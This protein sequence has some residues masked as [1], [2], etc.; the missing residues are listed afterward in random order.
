MELQKIREIVAQIDPAVSVLEAEAFRAEEDGMEYQVWKLTT[1]ETPLVLKKVNPRERETYVGF[2]AHGGPVPKVFC[3]Y[4]DWML[5]EYIPGHTLSRCRRDDLILTLDALIESQRTFWN[6]EDL[7]HVGYGFEK[8]YPNR[9]KR[10]ACME[11]LGDCYSAYLEAFQ[12]VPRTLCN[13]D[14]LPFN[15][16]ISGDRAVFLDW[17]FGG[18]LPYPCALARMIAYGEEAEN[19][20]FYMKR[21]DQEFAVEYYYEHLIRHMGIPYNEYIRTIKLF[22]FKEYSEWI[23]CANESGDFSGEYYQKYS[24]MARKLAKDLGYA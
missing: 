1:E 2:F 11:D 18:I 8:S 12:T 7:S 5:M 20:L 19:A 21:E 22:F 4:E 9:E 10:L 23:Y 16:I 15:V 3:F 14:L 17:E 13:D 24:V 6:R